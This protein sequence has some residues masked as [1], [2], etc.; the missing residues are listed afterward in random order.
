MS[1]KVQLLFI[2]EMKSRRVV[3]HYRP[4]DSPLSESDANAVASQQEFVNQQTEV[5][6]EFVIG[7]EQIYHFFSMN[8]NDAF[9]VAC[10]AEVQPA[11]K[12]LVFKM[13]PKIADEVDMKELKATNDDRF[14]RFVIT[15]IK[16]VEIPPIQVVSEPTRVD[17]KPQKPAKKDNMVQKNQQL[18]DKGVDVVS[19]MIQKEIGKLET[20]KEIDD[21][22][23]QIE[24]ITLEN[25]NIGTQIKVLSWWENQKMNMILYG[26][27]ALIV[28]LGLMVMYR[29]VF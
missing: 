22:L 21:E 3:F 6:Y 25:L 9:A 15:I 10:A 27:L 16:T 29:W 28:L 11:N 23:K 20:L 18:V 26:G 2:F 19:S 24:K 7:K 14:R 13:L 8:R 1:T 17:S 4:E 12:P 5:G